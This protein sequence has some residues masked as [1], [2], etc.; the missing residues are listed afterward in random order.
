MGCRE[1]MLRGDSF[2][3]AWRTAVAQS[4]GALKGEEVRILASLAD[5]LGTTDLDSQ[6][7]ALDYTGEQLRRCHAAAGQKR[8]KCQKLYG[9]LGV[10][11][12]LAVAII[13]I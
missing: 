1:R 10:L 11:A 13:L 7:S 4:P 9:T 2:P 3:V 5:V 12:G 6:L 8:D